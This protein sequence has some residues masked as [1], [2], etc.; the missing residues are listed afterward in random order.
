VRKPFALLAVVTLIVAAGC[1]SSGGGSATSDSASSGTAPGGSA[2]AIN[3]P[4]AP[5]VTADTIKVGVPYVDLASIKDLVKIDNGD[6]QKAYQVMFDDI[7]AKGGIN[8]RKLEPIYAPINPVGTAASDA[9]CT[10]LTQ[11]DPVF[12][13]VGFFLGDAVLCYV[14]TNQTAAIGGN[15]TAEK[16]AKAKAPWF[17]T[18]PSDDTAGD[19]VRAMA[20]AGKLSSNVAVL[21]TTADQ[22]LL[23]QKVQPVL[24]ELGVKPVSSAILDA[25]PNDAAANEAAAK[26]IA[27]KF[28]AAGAD[29]VVF[30]GN[31]A[32]TTFIPGMT[33]TDFRPQLIFTDLSGALAYTASAGTDTSVVQNAIAAGPYGPDQKNYE[34]DNAVTKACL[35]LQRKA[36]LEINPPAQ[37]PPGEPNQFSSSVLACRQVTLLAAIL[38]K[39]GPDLN[40]GTFETAGNSLGRID[41]AGYPD[42]W[43]FGSAPHSDGDPVL[44]VFNWN[45]ASKQFE[46]ANA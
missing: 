13:A 24:D 11:D 39:A 3:D 30:V 41:L 8:G 20:K 34:V 12:V 43:N 2:V 10:K 27:E 40:Y 17:S 33:K 35:D 36:G 22:A 16:L 28:K 45:A 9:A 25:P 46:P 21:A 38:Q 42:P 19:A 31:G 32:P 4:R 5:G 29:K 1:K 6:F 23:E 26:T 15:M 14:D 7:N 44:Y 37:V 18:D